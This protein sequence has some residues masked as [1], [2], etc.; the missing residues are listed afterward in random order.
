VAVFKLE[1]SKRGGVAVVHI[2]GEIALGK[3]TALLSRKTKEL[4]AAGVRDM[5]LDMQ[6]VPWLD[7]SGIGEVFACYKRARAE[8]GAVK[9]VLSGKSRSLFT[10]TELHRVFEIFDDLDAA[11]SSFD[12]A[13][14]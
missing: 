11:V 12:E 6:N 10:F 1:I 9:L 2:S 5:V 4:V 14:S 13:A 8:G 7:S 3:S